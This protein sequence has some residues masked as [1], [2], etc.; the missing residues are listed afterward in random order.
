MKLK[1]PMKGDEMQSLYA[2]AW[3]SKPTRAN[4]AEDPLFSGFHATEPE[5]PAEP[6][7]TAEE[8]EVL[9]AT[10]D[11]RTEREPSAEELN[12]MLHRKRLEAERALHLFK[13]GFTEL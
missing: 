10:M 6:D 8:A 7:T 3:F 4:G 12:W 2:L 13:L 5:V 1:Y 11:V 9:A